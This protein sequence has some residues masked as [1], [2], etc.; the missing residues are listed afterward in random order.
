MNESFRFKHLKTL[1]TDVVDSIL[2]EVRALKDWKSH[3]FSSLGTGRFAISLRNSSDYPSSGI[4]PVEMI[5]SCRDLIQYKSC[6]LTKKL[7]E[8]L[9][10]E[11]G[12]SELG[13]VTFSRTLPGA[14]IRSHIDGGPY[15]NA[16]HR[17]HVSLQTDPNIWFI[18]EDEKISMKK[19]EVWILD[20][21][22]L[23]S[24]VNDGSVERINLFFDAR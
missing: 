7:V 10:V 3:K 15:F 5:S 1:S 19:G 16:F 23:H 24:V 8:D 18:C 2:A 22:R 4:A 12:W 13:L 6:S 21:K 9:C 17:V 14:E 11:Y 20:N